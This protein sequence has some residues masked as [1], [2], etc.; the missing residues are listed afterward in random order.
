MK[1]L[2]DPLKIIL[3]FEKNQ[4]LDEHDHAQRYLEDLEGT[5]LTV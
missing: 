4:D 1:I 2:E 5:S 3:I